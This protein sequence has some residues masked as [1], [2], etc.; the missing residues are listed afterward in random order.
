M[1]ACIF[2]YGNKDGM[3]EYMRKHSTT[4]RCDTI[5]ALLSLATFYPIR[6]S[7]FKIM[8]PIYKEVLSRN[9]YT[10]FCPSNG[11]SDTEDKYGNF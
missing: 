10:Y 7:V 11:L 9:K 4:A 1:K 8:G 2:P 5:I 6:L 3:K